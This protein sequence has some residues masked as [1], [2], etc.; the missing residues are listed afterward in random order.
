MSCHGYNFDFDTVSMILFL[1]FKIL[2]LPIWVVL[3]LS[4]AMLSLLLDFA[5]FAGGQLFAT[6]KGVFSKKL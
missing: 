4:L 2:L 6:A 5:L 1:E 3:L